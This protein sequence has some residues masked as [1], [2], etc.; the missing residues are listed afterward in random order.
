[1]LSLWQK[2]TSNLST[3]HWRFKTR[4]S[5]CF[6]ISCLYCMNMSEKWTSYL[7]I[8]CP[9]LTC[10][11]YMVSNWCDSVFLSFLELQSVWLRCRKRISLK[12]TGGI[13]SLRLLALCLLTA[14]LWTAPEGYSHYL[15]ALFHRKHWKTE[16][17]HRELNLLKWNQNPFF[18][19]L[20]PQVYF[21][22]RCTNAANMR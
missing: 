18:F 5:V 9:N 4:N 1:M 3:H 12:K 7:T 6:V 15:D 16:S 22:Y 17:R 19:P 14:M 11:G 13:H 21:L 2:N 8:K 10:D 20:F